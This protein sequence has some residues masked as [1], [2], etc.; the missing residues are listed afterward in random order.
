V[1]TNTSVLLPGGR[2]SSLPTR[3]CGLD[4]ECGLAGPCEH[5]EVPVEILL[6]SFSF[7]AAVV[8]SQEGGCPG[9]DPLTGLPTPGNIVPLTLQT[10]VV[11]SG[12]DES[13]KRFT[14]TSGLVAGFFDANNCDNTGGNTGG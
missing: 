6:Y 8:A 4:R 9:V 2:C 3:H 11:F 13:G 5:V 10:S 7:K 14:V 1:T 12:S